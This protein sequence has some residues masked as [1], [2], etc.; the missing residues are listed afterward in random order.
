MKNEEQK[1]LS[2]QVAQDFQTA[3]LV[4]PFKMSPTKDETSNPQLG[5]ALIV[6]KKRMETL[7][8]TLRSNSICS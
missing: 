8:P 3:N 4:I 1:S 5:R 2:D 7:F 6:P